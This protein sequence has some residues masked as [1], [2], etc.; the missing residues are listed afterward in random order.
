MSSGETASLGLKCGSNTDPASNKFKS[1]KHLVYTVIAGDYDSLKRPLWRCQ[2]VDYLAFVSE[3]A[4]SDARGWRLLPVPNHISD[5]KLINRE[6]KIIGI[7]VVEEYDSIIYVDGSI[8][9]IGSLEWLITH[10]LESGR[11]L[12]LFRHGDRDS[13][14]E[15]LLACRDLGYLSDED[16]GFEKAR[17]Q[18]FEHQGAELGLFDAGV[19]LKNPRLEAL[20]EVSERWFELF[21][22]NPVRDQLSLP[23]VVWEREQAILQLEHWIKS[24]TPTFLRYPHK[25]AEPVPKFLFWLGSAFPRLFQLVFAFS[26]RHRPWI[27]DSIAGR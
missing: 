19:I 16:Y 5:P 23:I 1:G 10:F 17:L 22:Q 15:E 3:P 11:A 27:A 13:P 25:T 18:L 7:D 24:Y 8:Q 26:R 12:G 6:M 2:N 14:W 20:A 21:V 4:G 9:I